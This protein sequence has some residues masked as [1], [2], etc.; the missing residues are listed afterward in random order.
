MEEIRKIR[1]QSIRRF[2]T[3]HASHVVLVDLLFVLNDK[4]VTVGLTPP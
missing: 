1:P 2:A 4:A 3:Q